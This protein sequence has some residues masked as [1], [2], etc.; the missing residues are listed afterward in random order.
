MVIQDSSK[1]YY[2]QEANSRMAQYSPLSRASNIPINIANMSVNDFYS[3]MS[4]SSPQSQTQ[5][6]T[7]MQTQNFMNAEEDAKAVLNARLSSYAPLAK[8][9][10][11]QFQQQQQQIYQKPKTWIDNNINMENILV[12]HEELPVI[13]H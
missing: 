9:T 1:D 12:A 11:Y 8:T 7:Q 10:Q 2:R 4:Q 6:Q 5:S 3:N 13:S